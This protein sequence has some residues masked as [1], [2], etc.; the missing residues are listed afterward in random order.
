MRAKLLRKLGGYF[1]QGVLL[2]AP[3]GV[4]LYIIFQVFIFI[5]GIIPFDVPGLGVVSL[6][7]FLTFF[8]WIGSSIIAQPI[9]AYFKQIM[10]KAP[11]IKTVYT[12]V[13]DL[14]AAFV[15]QKKKFNQPVLVKL[16]KDSN[17]EKPG[18]ITRES[19]DLLGIPKGK[20]AVYLPHSYAWSGNLFIVPEDQV[21]P[22]SISASEMMKFIVSGGVSS[23]E[24]EKETAVTS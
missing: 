11:I 18:F 17:L 1:L 14:V 15:G 7:V 24:G 12:S 8:G 4:T 2:T 20:V 6:L 16:T 19:L 10:D 3:I 21:T 23:L 13:Q 5:D 22:L 9:T